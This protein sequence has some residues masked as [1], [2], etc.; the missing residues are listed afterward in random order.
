MTV[1]ATI[2]S[3]EAAISNHWPTPIGCDTIR[4]TSVGRIAE[5]EWADL[6]LFDPATVADNTTPGRPDAP[7]TGI[8]AV[9]ISG[10]VV[11]QDGQIVG[12]ERQGR[13]LRR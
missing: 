9:L 12:R 13:V 5:G 3:T 11:A 2:P 7:P 4:T 6:V 10:Q 8:R 1:N